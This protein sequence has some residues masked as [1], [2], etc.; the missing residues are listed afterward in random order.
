MSRHDEY[1]DPS[2]ADMPD[3]AL[4]A[5]DELPG[6]L[7]ILAEVIGVRDSLLVAE[8]IGGTMLR[9]P[10]V[11]PLKIKWRNRWMRQRYDQGGI[12]VIE[13]ARSHGL[14]ERQTYNILGAVE[15]DDKQMRLW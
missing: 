3:E 11:R 7:P 4:P 2:I 5:I 8:K 10:S 12:T 6:D 1:S 13:L 14:G 15:P 9:L